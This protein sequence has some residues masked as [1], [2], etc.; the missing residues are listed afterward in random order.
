MRYAFL[1]LFYDIYRFVFYP[2][3][4]FYTDELVRKG[5][6]PFFYNLY[7]KNRCNHVNHHTSSLNII[8]MSDIHWGAN[9]KISPLLVKR[10]I[11]KTNTTKVFSGGDVITESDINKL[12]MFSLWK[13]FTSSYYFL[14]CNFYQIYGNH[15][16]N[17][18]CQSNIEAVF[19][20]EEVNSLLFI[21]DGK[22]F[23]SGYSYYTDDTSSTT[24]FICLDT[25]KQN[26]DNNDYIN[27][28]KTL[29][30]TPSN[31]HIIIFTHIILEWMDKCYQSKDYIIKLLML[32][33]DHNMNNSSKIEAILAG[34]I[35]NDYHTETNGGIPIITIGADAYG[36][37]CGKYKKSLKPFSESSFVVLSFNYLE[38]KVFGTRIGRGDDFCFNL[39]NVNV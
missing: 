9:F 35:H 19:S 10:I 27:I 22:R 30:S 25:G 7:I 17:S 26:L 23:G 6:L 3:Y 15:D 12:S 32:L 20:N 18:F 2:L 8:F 37:A 36:V 11:Q 21:G 31:W 1:K 34:H 14:G 29:D 13:Q 38:K 28:K 33:D 24:R 39:P 4:R 16:N 5:K